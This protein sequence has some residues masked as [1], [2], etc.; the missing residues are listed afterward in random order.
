MFQSKCPFLVEL[1]QHFETQTA[2]FLLLEHA[3]GGVVW[4]HLLPVL[5]RRDH[6]KSQ[7]YV[8]NL[9]ET[10][11][12]K[13]R[14]CNVMNKHNPQPR[15]E[16]RTND[17]NREK[18][19]VFASLDGANKENSFSLESCVRVWM[20][21]I[22]VAVAHLHKHGIIC[23]LVGCFILSNTARFDLIQRDLPP[24]IIMIDDDH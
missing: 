18:S 23:R 20:A 21:E 10:E 24:C 15:H 7:S 12:N 11:L 19:S 13:T 4:D 8:H 22:V 1:H 14:S 3:R 5:Q 6:N 9:K 17:V 16:N 2:V